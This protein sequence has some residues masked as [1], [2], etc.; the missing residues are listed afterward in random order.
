MMELTFPPNLNVILYFNT[1]VWQKLHE[2]LLS[3]TDTSTIIVPFHRTPVKSDFQ[4][5][6]LCN[7]ILLVLNII[8]DW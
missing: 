6:T 3:A 2:V 1:W 7:G 4:N 5:R 8:H